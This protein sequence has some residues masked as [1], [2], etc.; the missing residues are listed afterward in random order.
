[1]ADKIEPIFIPEFLWGV[2]LAD[3]LSLPRSYL[4]DNGMGEYEQAISVL[5]GKYQE[6][7][8]DGAKC[9]VCGINFADQIDEIWEFR[10]GKAILKEIR[11]VCRLCREARNMKQFGPGSLDEAI[12][13]MT[14]VNDKTKQDSELAVGK[15][16]LRW[17]EVNSIQRWEIKIENGSTELSSD[18]EKKLE[19]AL[20]VLLSRKRL[21]R[22]LKHRYRVRLQY[23]LASLNF[24][25]YLFIGRII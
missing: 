21:L 17:K 15:A 22:R 25:F 12:D 23:C 14:Y 9:S 5:R 11:P 24:N 7:L 8:K 6:K 1:M 13:W 18:D 20:N 10:E 16:Y 3:L 19:T 4:L 2:S